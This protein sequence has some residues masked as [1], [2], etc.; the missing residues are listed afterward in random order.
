MDSNDLTAWA[1]HDHPFTPFY[2]SSRVC[3]M[4]D[5]AHATTPFQ[6]QGAGQAIEDALTLRAVLDAA[7]SRDDIRFA[8]HAYD[9]ARRARGDKVVSTSRYE[10][11]VYG[12]MDPR[13]G[14]DLEKLEKEMEVSYQ[15]MWKRDLK[16]QNEQAVKLMKE[17][18]G[19]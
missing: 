16:D 15:W 17:A 18:M 11:R 2:N 6:G 5:A 4:G 13:I 19:I 12:F 3:I 9:M 1:M 8:F 7:K 14:S 10:G